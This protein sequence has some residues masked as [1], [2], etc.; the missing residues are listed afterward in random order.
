[1]DPVRTRVTRVKEHELVWKVYWQSEEYART[2]NPSAMLRPRPLPG[3]PHRR[4]AAQHRRPLR[5]AGGL[6]GRLPRS[7]PRT[8]HAYPCG[9]SAR[10]DTRSGRR[11]RPRAGGARPAAQT[12]HA[13]SAAGPRIRPC[14]TAHR[15][16]RPTSWLSPSNNSSNP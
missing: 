3:R 9:R 14:V 7:H 2:Q 6:G 15:P 11:A 12:A 5:A 10:R 16:P 13:V 1:M 8:R 4:R